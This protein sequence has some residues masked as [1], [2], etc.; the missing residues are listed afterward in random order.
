MNIV[1]LD[2][3][4][5]EKIFFVELFRCNSIMDLV[6]LIYRKI[7]SRGG[8]RYF[9][10][11]EV[12]IDEKN[13]KYYKSYKNV[14]GEVRIETNIP[15]KEIEEEK[16]YKLEDYTFSK[17]ILIYKFGEER[18]YGYLLLDYKGNKKNNKN[19][20][21]IKRSFFKLIVKLAIQ[22]IKIKKKYK[23]KNKAGEWI[24][25]YDIIINA[26]KDILTKKQ[27]IENIHE[28]LYLLKV[29]KYFLIKEINQE[30]YFDKKN[31]L[32]ICPVRKLIVFQD[33]EVELS[34]NE[35]EIFIFFI[36]NLNKPVNRLEIIKAVWGR[37]DFVDYRT[38][39]VYIRRIRKK[40]KNITIYN[41]ETVRDYGYMLSKKDGDE[42]SSHRFN[43]KL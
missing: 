40:I 18:V 11:L 23:E 13:N 38:V 32:L 8:V 14:D 37:E 15:F 27:Q 26:I 39:D 42:P 2:L 6:N 35:F 22:N 28:I 3:L 36:K 5:D 29:L 34:K 10:F 41:I 12:V 21:F 7:A 17:D 9:N 43:L 4:I 19:I 25:T 24:L 1:N 33:I 30:E 31:K 16:L 20:L